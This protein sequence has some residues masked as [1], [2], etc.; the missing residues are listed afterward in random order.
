MMH[1]EENVLLK[2]AELFLITKKEVESDALYLKE[3]EVGYFQ[4]RDKF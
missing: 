4:P 3:S 1:L 2:R